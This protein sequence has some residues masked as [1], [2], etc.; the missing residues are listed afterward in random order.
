MIVVCANDYPYCVLPQGTT[1]DQASAFC[2]ERQ[3][4]DVRNVD[5]RKRWGDSGVSVFYHWHD[6]LVMECA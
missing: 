3:H 4:N 5:M 2:K 6:V 1:E